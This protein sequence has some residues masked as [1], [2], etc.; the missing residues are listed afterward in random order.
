MAVCPTEGCLFSTVKNISGA[1]KKFGFLPPHGRELEDEEEITVFG[2]ITS[3]ISRGEYVTDRRH[4]CALGSAVAEEELAIVASPCYFV[5]DEADN[6]SYVLDSDEGT[7]VSRAPTWG[8][9][10]A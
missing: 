10:D 3:A 7:P 4:Q 6:A 5:F 9:S 2:S 8:S 1:T